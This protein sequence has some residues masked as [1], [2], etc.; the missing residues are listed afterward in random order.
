MWLGLFDH[1]VAFHGFWYAPIYCWLLLV[2][3]WARR[4]P[5]LW[6]TL[7]LLA[8]GIVE[9]IAFN[10]SYF[11]ALLQYRFAGGPEGDTFTATRA[12]MDPLTH[13][14]PGQFLLSPGLWIGFAVAAAFLAAA[15]RL[16]RYRDPI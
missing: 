10:T 7:P 2:S 8:I 13:L 15:V 16:R 9:K 5:I 4:A 14:H 3:A 6:A 12:S 11:A 1:L